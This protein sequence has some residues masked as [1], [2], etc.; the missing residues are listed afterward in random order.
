MNHLRLGHGFFAT[1]CLMSGRKTGLNREVI[2][3]A[4]PWSV[5]SNC[6]GIAIEV[7]TGVSRLQRLGLAQ[8]PAGRTP[9]S[10]FNPAP[11]A[12]EDTH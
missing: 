1:L 2:S 7:A 5:F 11:D 8:D 4:R 6:I 10:Y 3:E 9:S 12:Y